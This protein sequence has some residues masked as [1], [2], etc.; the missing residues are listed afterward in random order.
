MT[1]LQAQH[2]YR[3]TLTPCPRCKLQPGS[4]AWPIPWLQEITIADGVQ[5]VHALLCRRPS[6]SFAEIIG[7]RAA[8]AASGHTRRAWLRAAVSRHPLTF[9][10]AAVVNGVAVGVVVALT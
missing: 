2:S 4:Q 1:P 3:V 5:S 10:A 6:C 7:L 9:A 8:S